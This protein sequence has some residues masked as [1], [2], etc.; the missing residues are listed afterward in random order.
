M[1]Y[2]NLGRI[3]PQI[4]VSCRCELLRNDEVR[5]ADSGKVRNECGDNDNPSH[6]LPPGS[7]V[8]YKTPSFPT[9]LLNP[10]QR[11]LRTTLVYIDQARRFVA[12]R[13][14]HLLFFGLSLWV[15][16]SEARL[17]GEE[18]KGTLKQLKQATNEV[19]FGRQIRPILAKHC[20]SCHGPQT[21]EA[22]LALH[23][24]AS[25]TRAL[26]S[27]S[28]AIVA[29]DPNHSEILRRIQSTDPS[30]KM[31]PEGEGLSA[32]QVQLLKD[33]I[34][35]GA[36]YKA[37]WAF[38]PLS[39]PEIPAATPSVTQQSR[40]MANPIDAFIA[41]GWQRKNLVG[42]KRADPRAL[43]RRLYFDCVGVPPDLETVEAFVKDPSES[44]YEELVD[45]LLADPRF[46]ERMAR[47]WLDL[48]RYAETNSYERDGPKPN[49]WYYRDYVIDSFNHDKSYRQFLT[50]Q[51]AGDEIENPTI[52]TLTATGFYRLGV[53]DD[54]PADPEQARFDGYDDLV[55][56]IGQGVLGLT[57]NCARCHDHKIDPIP[58]KD[59]YQLVAFLRDVTP[60][61]N[62]GDER[63][64]SQIDVSPSPVRGKLEAN[65]NRIKAIQKQLRKIENDGIAKM[66]DEDKTAAKSPDR[67]KV[68][69]VKLKE[70]ISETD[71]KEYEELKKES[72]K[73]NKESES[74]SAEYR[75]G[76]AKCDPKPPA[77]HV[78]MRG[79][80]AAPGEEVQP[81]FPTIYREVAPKIPEVSADDTTA[82]RRTVLAKWLT[83]DS[84][85]LTG[86][87]IVNRLWQHH[88]GR[89][90][91]R[92]SNNF[93]QMGDAP[94]HPELL[95]FLVQQ[96]NENDW[97]L[98]P[99]H[100]NMLMSETYRQSSAAE[101]AVVDAD[102]EN[103]LFARFNARRL[104]AEEIR[105]SVLAVSGRIAYKMHGPS[106]Y[107][108]VSD[109][110]KAG[111]SVPGKGWGKSTEAEQSR[112]SIYIHIKRS[113][114]PPELSVFDFPET[115]VTCEARFLTTQA[116]Q[117]L[118]M[119]N[120][121]F[122]QKHSTQLAAY[123]SQNTSA[124][125]DKLNKAI[126]GAFTRPATA[127]ELERGIA[128]I[129]SYQTKFSVDESQ[130][131]RLYCLVLLNS[132]EFVYLD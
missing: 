48:V 128:R 14:V 33:W 123:A 93:G 118:N 107:P 63:S 11:T 131:F 94:T 37:H 98:K 112:R 10:T 122:M 124:L 18:D 64:N 22:G 35:V 99:L 1:L 54:E 57:M 103:D 129:Q 109:D 30:E 26:D 3:V 101:Q 27:G 32:T 8:E 21:Q 89:G 83:S 132:N 114:V 115:D 46:G 41:K 117:A 69:E 38:E 5:D 7:E 56:T 28:K 66:S 34:Q 23:E 100:R 6:T 121:S 111:Q 80:P 108:D 29:G 2:P 17:R 85:R 40:D 47:G 9:L 78:L 55:T 15:L 13:S 49:A 97:R 126:S 84:N 65:K 125:K 96:L 12:N 68:L 102:P 104:S 53:W 113:L 88:F 130:A 71:W 90:I 60:Y 52:E 95:D 87:V 70:Y 77:T 36:E 81:G 127:T 39:N 20:Y 25:A 74:I 110:V 67:N 76:L 106:I 119:L 43:V 45:K 86:R 62:R 16:A 59:Y 24:F 58:Q 79:S 75:L 92:S 61:G 120:G 44:A 4:Q 42:S 51:I 91:V 72:E 116:A 19:D 50:E 73:L 105:D 82:N 31:P